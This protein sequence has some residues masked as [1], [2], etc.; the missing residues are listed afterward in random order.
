M[1]VLGRLLLA[2]AICLAVAGII[3]LVLKGAGVL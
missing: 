2:C 1:G 3:Y